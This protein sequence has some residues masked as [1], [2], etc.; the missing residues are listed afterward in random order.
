MCHVEVTSTP[1]DCKPADAH[2]EEQ[3]FSACDSR[4]VKKALERRSGRRRKQKLRGRRPLVSCQASSVGLQ[5]GFA[6]NVATSIHILGLSIKVAPT[7]GHL[8]PQNV[9]WVMIGERST[10]APFH[11]TTGVTLTSE[12]QRSSC[13]GKWGAGEHRSG[14]QHSIGLRHVHYST[15]YFG[16][17]SQL[18]VYAPSFLSPSSDSACGMRL[19]Q[20][21]WSYILRS[22]WC[23]ENSRARVPYLLG[24][25]CWRR[26]IQP[27]VP[28]HA[29]QN[30][31]GTER[32]PSRCLKKGVGTWLSTC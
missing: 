6:F 19:S 25:G 5:E 7:L 22:G 21:L 9:E 24:P 8:E 28:K 10:F 20:S 30:A 15:A 29:S 11:I 17:V 26:L 32:V 27:W 2:D 18:P 23:L 12:L 3:P 31:A 16:Q 1:Q 13:L 14:V 4:L